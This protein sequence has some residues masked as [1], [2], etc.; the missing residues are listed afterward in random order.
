MLGEA[1]IVFTFGGQ[2][3]SAIVVVTEAIEELILGIDWL[4]S[5]A[6]RWDFEHGRLGLAT[7]GFVYRAVHAVTR[8]EAS[9]L[10][11]A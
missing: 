9:M 3:H 7:G 6:C 5:K 11:K 4:A 2:E 8:S 10:R 1:L